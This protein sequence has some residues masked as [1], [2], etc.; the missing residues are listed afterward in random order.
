MNDYLVWI[1]IFQG[2][3]FNVLILAWIGSCWWDWK[4]SQKTNQSIEKEVLKN[5]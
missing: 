3:M 4:H 2:V 5:E 1:L